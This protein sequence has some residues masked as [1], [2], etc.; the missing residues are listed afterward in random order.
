M[1]FKEMTIEQLEERK[2]EIV[3]SLDSSEAEL[4]LN[5]L[6]EEVRGIKEELEKRAADEAKKAEIRKA[7]SLA[8]LS[9]TLTFL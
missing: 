7:V 4:D 3:V 9:V 5:A 8:A 6:E 1:D 2:A